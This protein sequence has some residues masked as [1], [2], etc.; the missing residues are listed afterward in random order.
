[1]STLQLSKRVG[2]GLAG[3]LCAAVLMAVPALALVGLD[4]GTTPAQAAEASVVDG[5]LLPFDAPTA[6]VQALNSK[7][8]VGK[9]LENWQY[10]ALIPITPIPQTSSPAPGVTV[11]ITAGALSDA[12]I[13]P[14]TDVI[15]DQVLSQ[16]GS[17]A[18]GF[19]QVVFR[20]FVN[21]F[22][23]QI[24]GVVTFT[25]QLAPGIPP[26]VPPTSL[27]SAFS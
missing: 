8:E 14:A 18:T 1:M 16:T 25:I 2:R 27:A 13:N 21:R 26:F 19:T 6:T 22:N 23:K 11:I 4:L 5:A 24:D 12:G 15:G 10:T 7:K 9:V 20:V 17:L 3:L